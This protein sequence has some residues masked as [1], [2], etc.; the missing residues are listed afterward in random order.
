MPAA[1]IAVTVDKKIVKQIDR[2][3]MEG[4][5][6]SRSSVI[7]EALEEKLKSKKRKRL[8]EELARLD[9]GEERELAEEFLQPDS[10][11]WDEY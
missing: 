10:G 3:V 8:A 9:P 1:K 11:E 6:K 7:Q 5:Y 4:K 2:L